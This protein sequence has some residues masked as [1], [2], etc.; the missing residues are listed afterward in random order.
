MTQPLF[1]YPEEAF[2]EKTAGEVDLPDDP[3]QWA[4]S[5][6]QELYKQV[7]Y[8]T[9]YQP[10]VQM[11]KVDAERGYGLG[12]VEI[13]NQ[14]EA[15]MDTD[16]EMMEATGIRMVRIPFIIRE[17][18]LSPFD[19][20]VNDMGKILPL[21]ENRLRQSLF[22][23][24]AFDVTSRTP[25]DQSMIGQLYPPYR[26]NYG[27]GGGGVAMN[28]QGGMGMGKAGSA[29][30]QYLTAEEVASLKG[31]K[32]TASAQRRLMDKVAC[33]SV[34]LGHPSL[35]QAVLPSATAADHARFTDEVSKEASYLYSVHRSSCPEFPE[36]LTSIVNTVPE[37]VKEGS[38]RGWV[39]ETV[40][41][42]RRSGNAYMAKTASHLMWEPELE[43]LD[44]GEVVRRYGVKLAMD[45]DTAGAVTLTNNAETAGDDSPSRLTPVAQPG[46]YKVKD[47][48]GKEHIGFVVPQLVDTDGELTPL[49]LFTNGTTVAVQSDI[50]GEK[51]GDGMNLPSGPIGKNGAFY[52][53][54][55][56]GIRMTVPFEFND[57]F[58]FGDQ[59]MVYAGQTFDG[60]PVEVSV[61]PNIVD[62][63][64]VDDSRVLVPTSWKWLP[65]DATQAVS[66]VGNEEAEALDVSEKAACVYV[67]SDGD[68]FSFTGLPVTKLAAVEKNWLSLDDAM[69][70]LAGLGVDQS[71]GVNKLA[72]AAA[73]QDARGIRVGRLIEPL[74]GQ[75]KQAM[76]QA[77]GF[78][79][80]LSGLK[81]PVLL[82]EAATFPDPSTVDVV[83]SL[84][85]INP[86]NVMSFV[87]YLPD[88]EDVQT[89]LCELLF[90]VRVGMKSVPQSALERAIRSLEET[91][92][93]LKVVGFQGS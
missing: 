48:S 33:C 93:G 68:N 9:D 86:E 30:E 77:R 28:A 92:E 46:L 43:A 66:L 40:V 13:Q 35:L 88:M 58:T 39:P 83:L 56:E 60:R 65:L 21:T 4:Q 89:K 23:A 12:H 63:T 2:V 81:Q 1:Y 18:K 76:E 15:P 54:R 73:F 61:Q 16:P 80:S 71:Y 25:G 79:D 17:K 27:F 44:R 41:Q 42:V 75:V 84:G 45:V 31:M 24:Q 78:V 29:L 19:L 47:S 34:R 26:Q 14:T 74:G 32:K 64:P 8:I 82:K 6:L 11:Q 91:I 67:R 20:I 10:H 36:I 55:P 59:P 50:Y 49:S 7:P 72:E 87:S 70:L 3:N 90:S 38:W 85:F 53:I 5:I 22:R 57:S 69:F 52:T 37:Q 62:V 51:S